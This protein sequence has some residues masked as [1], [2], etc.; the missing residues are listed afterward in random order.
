[1]SKLNY[2][3]V[4]PGDE[5]AIRS[6]SGTTVTGVMDRFGRNDSIEGIP[7]MSDAVNHPDPT[8]EIAYL[9]ATL[10]D[11]KAEREAAQQH[12][13][14]AEAAERT[15][16]RVR[17]LHYPADNDDRRS[18]RCPNCIG[19]AGV[20]PC[21]CWADEDRQPVCGHCNDRVDWPCPTIRALDGGEQHG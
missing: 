1:M 3:D 11:V 7:F 9:R 20:H 18:P 16:Q 14:R 6:P 13:A 8:V 15:I 4:M 12:Q 19:K 5:I 21:G 17:E 2:V 10:A